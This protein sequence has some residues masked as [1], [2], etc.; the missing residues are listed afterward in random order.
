MKTQLQ[1][2][3]VATS[4]LAVGP[5][6][7]L[8]IDS[9]DFPIGGDFVQVVNGTSFVTTDDVGDRF[10]GTRRTL[11]VTNTIGRSTGE[12]NSL[13]P[14]ALDMSNT[15]TGNGIITVLWDGIANVD[16]TENNTILG[17]QL[18]LPDAIDNDLTVTFTAGSG[19]GAPSVSR[20]FLSGTT[21]ANF[22]IPFGNQDFSDV[23]SL[24]ARFTGPVA[25]DA[26][27]QLIGT[28]PIPGTLLLM[29]VGLLGLAR[30]GKRAGRQG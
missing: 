17:F 16:L 23:T 22:F 9:F 13:T 25:W 10:L 20:T 15:T 21:G 27:V 5:A 28:A 24:T 4:L 1:L 26:V 6:S 11:T 8:T 19:P 29:G 3:L 12:I 14:D 7:A 18:T 2:A 30:W